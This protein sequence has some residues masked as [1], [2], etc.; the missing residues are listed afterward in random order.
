MALFCR[1]LLD[2]GSVL[3]F[4]K[5][6]SI[7]EF[8]SRRLGNRSNIEDITVFLLSSDVDDVVWSI[9]S[10]IV[11][12]LI[13]FLHDSSVFHRFSKSSKAAKYSSWLLKRGKL[14]K[15]QLRKILLMSM[16]SDPMSEVKA[17]VI[18]WEVI[19]VSEGV[20]L[21]IKSSSSVILGNVVTKSINFLGMRQWLKV[22]QLEIDCPSFVV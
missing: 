10:W 18:C 19:S 17:L 4:R 22:V 12:S 20:E 16:G 5:F 3:N 6:S 9:L 13:S 1:A 8:S 15:S 14:S 7:F 11:V 2:D 21:L